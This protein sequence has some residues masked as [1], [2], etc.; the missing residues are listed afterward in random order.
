MSGI[1]TDP[2]LEEIQ[3]CIGEYGLYPILW[4]LGN[5]AFVSKISRLE[6]EEAL[7]ILGFQ[8]NVQDSNPE[9]LLE[10]TS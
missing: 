3:D 10:F 7:I 2:Y 4:K 8:K 6:L 5:R 1:P 9:Y